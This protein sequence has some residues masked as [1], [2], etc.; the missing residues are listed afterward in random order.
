MIDKGLNDQ[1][2]E[3][4]E[5]TETLQDEY[6]ALVAEFGEGV[7]HGSGSSIRDGET[8][9]EFV[10]RLNDAERGIGIPDNWECRCRAR[11]H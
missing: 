3:L 10:R 5:P 8:F 2:A 4:I 9:A 1:Q 7:M 11:R 6:L